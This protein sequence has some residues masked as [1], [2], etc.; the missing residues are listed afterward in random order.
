MCSCNLSSNKMNFCSKGTGTQLFSL[1]SGL[2]RNDSKQRLWL[3][4]KKLSTIV[5]HIY[6][7]L[8]Y[9]RHKTAHNI[10][11]RIHFCT[12]SMKILQSFSYASAITTHFPEVNSESDQWLVS[13]VSRGRRCG[14][15]QAR[16][17]VGRRGVS[18]GT[19]WHLYGMFFFSREARRV[20]N[21]QQQKRKETRVRWWWFLRIILLVARNSPDANAF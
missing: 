15:R 3:A 17:V 5:L 21:S 6:R 13:C 8:K 1:F 20:T 7:I 12:Y 9:R 14:S 10:Y 11:M 4:P 18:P 16:L 2:W 19:A